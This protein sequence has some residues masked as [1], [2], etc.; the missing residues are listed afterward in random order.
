MLELTIPALEFYDETTNTFVNTKEQTLVL[1]HSLLSLQKW[2][3]I[4]HKPFLSKEPKTL[5]ETKSYIKCMTI[6][7]NIDPSVYDRLTNENIIAVNNYIENSMT[8]TTFSK[9]QQ[10]MQPISSREIMTAEI[11][12]HDMIALQIPFECKKWHL[13]QLLTLINV[14]S[15]KN[16]PPKKMSKSAIMSSNSSLNAARRAAMH[17]RG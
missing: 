3:S 5:D 13:N 7:Q 8:A 6:T 9:N 10:A 4:H 2:E 11:I 15:I 1:E 16:T 17:S 14:C 12:Y